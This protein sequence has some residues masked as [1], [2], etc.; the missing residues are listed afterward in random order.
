MINLEVFEICRVVKEKRLDGIVM[1]V[2]DSNMHSMDLF[3]EVQKVKWIGAV[4]VGILARLRINIEKGEKHSHVLVQGPACNS[5]GHLVAWQTVDTQAFM[6]SSAKYIGDRAAVLP[7]KLDW[8][9]FV[10]NSRL[11]WDGTDKPGWVK[12]MEEVSK[13]GEDVENPLSLLK[14]SSIVE[15][16]GGCGR[17]VFLWWLRVEARADSKFPARL[18][19]WFFTSLFF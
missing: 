8:A 3:D 9:G 7:Q 15:P 4:S 14:D 2:D 19:L 17:K 5:S 10:L 12:E 11:V 16:L 1:F 13:D 6:E 18:V